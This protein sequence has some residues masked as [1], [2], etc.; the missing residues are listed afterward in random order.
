MNLLLVLCWIIFY[1]FF[2]KFL[3]LEK[4]NFSTKQNII[5]AILNG[6]LIYLLVL[7]FSSMYEG[8]MNK[9]I[10]ILVSIF[11]LTSA[12]RLVNRNFKSII[13]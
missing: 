1:Y 9:N 2:D 6:F 13:A 3:I 10:L 5:L 7:F 12:I 4:S 8:L 11:L